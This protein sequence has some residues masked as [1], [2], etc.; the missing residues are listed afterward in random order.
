MHLKVRTGRGPRSRR[1]EIVAG[2]SAAA[3]AVCAAAVAVTLSGSQ[4]SNPAVTAQIEAAMIAAPIAVGLFVWYR[5]PWRRFGKLLVA[6][7]FALSL[8]T[9]AQSSSDLVYSAGRVFGWLAEPLLIYL[10]LAFP[11]GRLTT[12]PARFLIAASVLLVAAFYLPTALLVD[13]Y[14]TPSPWSSCQA[15]CPGNAFMLV[16]SEPGFIDNVIVPFRETATLIL[17]T[18]MIAIVA[19][20]IRRGSHLRRITL[21]PVLTVAILHA[22]AF[23]A[24]IV[25][26]RIDRGG[27]AAEALA[28]IAALTYGGIALGFLAG[29]SGWRL[30]ESKALRRLAAAFAAHPPSLTLSETSELL[31]GAMDPSLKIVGGHGVSRVPGSTPRPGPWIR[32]RT[33]A[34][35]A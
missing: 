16:G 17:F 20:R 21:V 26:R 28:S 24:G 29:L 9:L 2:L 25:A 31:S 6:A 33:R 3:I 22:L 34:F 13:S 5:D 10:V 4:S 12:R 1:F 18:G 32:G 23:I 30:F 15:G 8:T 7:G 14:P 35:G 19:A 27:S 11:S